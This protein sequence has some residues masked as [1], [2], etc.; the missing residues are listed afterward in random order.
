MVPHSSPAVP[1]PEMHPREIAPQLVLILYTHTH[2]HTHT[3]AT[4]QIPISRIENS[5][6]T[7]YSTGNCIEYPMMNHNGK[8]FFF[9]FLEMCMYN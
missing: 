8:G 7:M 4:L 1:L 2:T 6:L 9:S 5:F 3:K